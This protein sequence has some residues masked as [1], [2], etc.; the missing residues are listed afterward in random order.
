M[1]HAL[2]REF[3]AGALRG[4]RVLHDLARGWRF[5]DL[6]FQMFALYLENV[7][8]TIKHYFFYTDAATLLD[9]INLSNVTL[10]TLVATPTVSNVVDFGGVGAGIMSGAT[11]RIVLDTPVPQDPDKYIALPTINLYDGG[12]TLPRATGGI[13]A[14]NINGVTKYRPCITLYNDMTGAAIPAWTTFIGSTRRVQ[15][16]WVGFLK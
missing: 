15:I 8:G 12:N 6:K 7:G 4:L 1:I 11:H 14:D 2:S 5:F 13:T 9:R 3:P 16:G 10:G